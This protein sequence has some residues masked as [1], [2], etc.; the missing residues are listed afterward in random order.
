MGRQRDRQLVGLF[1]TLVELIGF[2]PAWS[3]M[4]IGR[5]PDPWWMIAERNGIAWPTH[6]H[7]AR[8]D[9][10]QLLEMHAA[11]RDLVGAEGAWLVAELAAGPQWLRV[12]AEHDITVPP[13]VAAPEVA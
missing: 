3:T 13:E 12:A 2:D 9:D 4:S 10:E 6:R 8:V 5:T 7:L 11:Y 1:R